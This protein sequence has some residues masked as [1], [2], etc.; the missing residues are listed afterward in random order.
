MV[1]VFL[2]DPEQRT[3]EDKANTKIYRSVTLRN[4]ESLQKEY[5]KLRQRIL[6]NRN[7]NAARFASMRNHIRSID[8][9]NCDQP[10]TNS[11]DPLEQETQPLSREIAERLITNNPTGPLQH[12]VGP[13][14]TRQLN[15]ATS[16]KT[17]ESKEQSQG[18]K[19]EDQLVPTFANLVD[20][21]VRRKGRQKESKEGIDNAEQPRRPHHA[22]KKNNAR[23]QKGGVPERKAAKHHRQT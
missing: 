17:P 1:P 19:Q 4:Y 15:E 3:I 5:Q 2:L 20:Q 18:V 12:G 7:Y 23:M 22:V 11:P 10:S 14:E 8:T 21:N 13:G 9:R 6:S 16:M